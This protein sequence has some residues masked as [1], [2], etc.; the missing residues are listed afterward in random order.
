MRLR[1]IIPEC[2]EWIRKGFSAESLKY[3]E[4]VALLEYAMR[5]D[6]IDMIVTSHNFFVLCY[7]DPD[8]SAKKLLDILDTIDSN[9]K[10]PIVI[11]IDFALKIPLCHPYQVNSPS[12]VYFLDINQ[13]N[14]YQYITNIWECWENKQKCSVRCFRAQNN[15]RRFRFYSKTVGLLSCGDIAGYCH[16]NGTF[17]P[18]ADI[19][20]DLS[21]ES[22]RGFSSQYWIPPKIIN[23]WKKSHIVI[24]TQQVKSVKRYIR[25]KRYPY[26]FSDSFFDIN[27]NIV[28][29]K[30]NG[31]VGVFID[32]KIA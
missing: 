24:I 7:D 18:Y 8:Q 13:N 3:D 20:L 12:V 26:I 29:Y 15:D 25:K 22:L 14:A 21:H 19:Y 2:Q 16:N 17:L 23:E 10:K 27:T 1:A 28:P 9:I 4:R 11:G 6:N 32:I 5:D 31:L 30:L